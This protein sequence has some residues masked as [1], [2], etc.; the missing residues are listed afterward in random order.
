MEAKSGAQISAKAFIQS[1]LI[2]FAIMMIAGVL[3]L[4]IP[5]GRYA[6]VI[7]DGRELIAPDSFQFVERPIIPSGAGL[8]LR[9]K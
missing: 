2:L 1:V 7:Q 6:R 8:R 4:M 9:W 5:A 3:T